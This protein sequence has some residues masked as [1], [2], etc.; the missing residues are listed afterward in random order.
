T[1]VESL[2]QRRRPVD[3]ERAAAPAL[4]KSLP[5]LSLLE[6]RSDTVRHALDAIDHAF[7]VYDADERFLY[8][9]RRYREWYAP[10][11]E[12]LTPGRSIVEI[13]HAWYGIVGRELTPPMTREE[14]VRRTIARHRRASGV[15]MELRSVHR[16]IAV[17]E[18]RMMDGGVVA[19]RRDITQL[20]RLESDLRD[21]HR[22][23]RD[24]AE[25]SY[26]WYWR[27]DE[28]YRYVEVSAAIRLH[29]EFRR[30][31]WYG[32]TRW[33]LNP[34]HVTPERWAAHRA[35]L[36]RGEPFF[37]FTYTAITDDGKL[38]W[39]SSSGKPLFDPEGRF[40]GY[41]GIGRDVTERMEAEARLRDSEARFR[42]LTELSA[43]WYW[44]QDAEFRFVRFEGRGQ[45]G[46]VCDPENIGKRRWEMAGELPSGGW[47][48]HIATC[49]AHQPFRNLE[50]VRFDHD[51]TRLWISVSGEPRFDK[52]GEFQGYRGVGSDITSRK[53]IELKL[54]QLA[55][56]DDLTGLANRHLLAER[57]QQAIAL[58]QRES[59]HCAV[60]FIDLDRIRRV[61]NTWGHVAGD[62][63]LTEVAKRIARR[64]RET[65]TVGRRGGDEFLVVLPM[66]ATPAAAAHVS[67]A[68][69][70]AISEPLIMNRAQ[71]HVT[72]SIGISVFPDDGD[73][74]ET[75][76][77][78]A[79]AA[80][81]Y[82]KAHGR[83]GYH[84]YTAAM[85][86]RVNARLDLEAR[87]R[88]ALEKNELS[89]VYQP[90]YA[91][92]TGAIV[93]VE[94]LLRWDDPVHG[95][96][97]PSDFID[98][99]EETGMILAIG[100]WVL[101]EACT[102]ARQWTT[103]TANPPPVAV[104]ISALQFQQPLLPELVKSVLAE[105]GL[106]ARQ[107][108]LEVTET[109][110]MRDTTAVL[111]VLGRLRGFGVSI[112][113][114]DFGTGYSSLGYLKRFPIDKL[115]IDK[116]FIDGCAEA[117]NDAAIASAVIALGRALNLTVVAEG[118]ENDNQLEFL[119]V[120]GCEVVQGHW[121]SLPLPAAGLRRLLS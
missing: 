81:Y 69:L 73:D 85:H 23:L 7:V 117:G 120:G 65:D 82:T 47:D 28:Q 1:S 45:H 10:I 90:Q 93:G 32:K 21:Q 6:L 35:L 96:L 16:W 72:A 102:E 52:W 77:Q 60:L 27:Q 121:L 110:L 108:E 115:K 98:V 114:D 41:H 80:M 111:D 119:R 103:V 79:D 94:A 84:F 38:R 100:E 64:V 68:I 31:D 24:L 113:I 53:E 71:L 59:C 116:T 112:A 57:I 37:D 12:L 75:L 33:E 86:E 44:E 2:D 55:R 39:F 89:L 9:N 36:D 88:N 101:R 17:A 78:R 54:A 61:N 70:D 106:P 51:G 20:K 11:A 22:V 105:T 29:G 14:Y 19:L 91:T 40:Q 62:A 8:C 50:F 49:R 43:D 42:A 107:L 46:F 15:E 83:N 92:G 3:M 99:A 118:V 48:A 109:S 13:L 63:L 67:Q 34:G 74:Q 56:Y 95:A 4:A 104:N 26:N 25:L 30:E 76:I 66:I 97:Q 18:H 5:D 87:L 58:A